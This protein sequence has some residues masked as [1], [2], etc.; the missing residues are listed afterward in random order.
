MLGSQVKRFSLLPTSAEHSFALRRCPEVRVCFTASL[1]AVLALSA[2][3]SCQRTSVGAVNQGLP[4]RLLLAVTN[5]I[6]VSS[7]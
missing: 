4:S 5:V 1:E 6:A 2:V 3:S 7:F